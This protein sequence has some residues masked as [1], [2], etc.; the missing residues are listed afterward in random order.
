MLTVREHLTT[1]INDPEFYQFEVI[2]RDQGDPVSRS[3]SAYVH[4]NID[5]GF[6]RGIGFDS[7]SYWWEVEENTV[8]EKGMFEL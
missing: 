6:P 1:D 3:D 5:R 2:A 4:I 8:V 7:S